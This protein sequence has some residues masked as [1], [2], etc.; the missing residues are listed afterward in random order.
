[1]SDSL[2]KTRKKHIADF[3]A[4]GRA[5]IVNG[6]IDPQFWVLRAL[7]TNQRFD[8]NMALWYSAVYLVFYHLGSATKAWQLYP[9]PMMIRK[10]DWDPKIAFFKQRRN[11]RANNDDARKQL[12]ELMK[13]SD[14][15]LAGWVMSAAGVGGEEGWTLAREQIG[16]LH[17]HG[18][19]SSYKWCDM[20]K[21]VHRLPITAPDI[22]NKPGAT[23]GPIAGLATLL[24]VERKTVAN[25]LQL[26]R[27]LL[28]CVVEEHGMPAIG[29][30]HLESVLCDYQSLR[31]GRYYVGHDIDRD[32]SQLLSSDV[33]DETWW[34]LWRARKRIFDRRLLGEV[35]GWDGPRNALKTAYRDR[36][37]L[38][39][40]YEDVKEVTLL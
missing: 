21:F 40:V 17:Q 16:S 28:K 4:F 8:L 26:P 38:I 7:Y 27:D 24:G 22:G 20:L 35:N 13:R 1:M 25:D 2:W 36:E 10:K 29:L 19:W 9:Q 11:L 15:D 37:R 31:N 39:N 5:M 33:R 6:D 18:P 3:A 12:N 14:G 23:A 34:L 30:D 32:L